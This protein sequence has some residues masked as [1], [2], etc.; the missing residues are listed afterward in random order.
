MKGYRYSNLRL[1]LNEGKENRGNVT[2][3][4]E[5]SFSRKTVQLLRVSVS[6][7]QTTKLGSAPIQ[8]T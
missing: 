3:Y 1:S 5:P 7:C 6:L 2:L 8:F 4:S